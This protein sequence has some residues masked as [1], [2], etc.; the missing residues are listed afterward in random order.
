MI[1]RLISQ[2]ISKAAKSVLLLGPRQTGKSTL[3]HSLKPDLEINLAHEPTFL[4]FSSRSDSLEERLQALPKGK[5]IFID[6]VQR[7]PSIL[8]TVQSLIDESKRNRRP[9]KFY[10]SGSSARKLRRGGANL[11]PGR[12]FA[13]ELGPL[14]A[15]ELDYKVD[16]KKALEF[17]SLPDPWT[18]S[19]P[20][21]R[22]QLL[23][24]YAATYLKEEI[25]VEL[26][27]RSLEGFSR[28][29]MVAAENSG[30]Y[31]DLSKIAARARVPR[32]AA[33]RYFE[34]LEDTLVAHKVERFDGA[35]DADL[36][37][38]PRFFFFDVGVLHGILRNFEAS[39]DRIGSLFE[40]FIF[41]QIHYS[42]K[43]RN[44]DVKIS[45]FRT[46]NGVEVDFIVEKEKALFAIECKATAHVIDS[47]TNSL[48]RFSEYCSRK[49]ELLLV[50]PSGHS[51][52][53]GKVWVLP[54]TE[55]LKRMGL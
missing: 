6:E 43:A 12:V 52:K 17:G 55:A 2:E 1:D 45:G 20:G 42:A 11:L 32:Q 19:D 15:A 3:I 50:V 33:V 31:L 36:V 53:M 41:S 23:Q 29:L 24:T 27:L 35:G 18:S 7:L 9:L 13:F 16:I 5:T 44:T 14:V 49:H 25:Q 28:F 37:K 26:R 8:N 51:K 30:K 39:S 4:E 46:R 48:H 21:Y 10:L 38:H 40:H 22:R 34:I 54:W 47:D